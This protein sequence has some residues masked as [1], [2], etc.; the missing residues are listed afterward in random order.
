MKKREYLIKTFS[1][2]KK[3]DYENYVL[4]AIWH[5]LDNMDLKPVSQQ[6]VRRQNGSY[7][8]MD[9]YFPQLHI[10]L[11]VDEAHHAA[12]QEADRLRMDDIISAVGEDDISDFQC[13]RIDVTKS[14]EEINDKINEIVAIIQDKASDLDL[15]WKSYD[16][17]LEQ[18]K[19]QDE[20][21]IYDDFSFTYIKDIANTVFGKNARGYQQSYFRLKDKLWLWCPKLS[22][23]ENGSARSIAGGWLNLLAEDWSHIDESHEDPE[24]VE[25]RKTSYMEEFESGKE[26]AV[27]A[28]Y[29]D[30]LGFN[31]YRFIGIFKVAGPSPENEN[32]LRYERIN[33]RVGIV[34]Q[35]MLN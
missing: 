30:N 11:E 12:N 35:M 32:Y 21:T 24:V 5:K 13:F 9:L 1:R 14:L 2:T 31:R 34:K 7:A 28:K 10:G 17:E 22:I 18:L 6:Y 29:R 27:F 23:T 8:L 25:A 20:L 33:D 15:N 26:R 4:T 16:E 3:K 19:Q